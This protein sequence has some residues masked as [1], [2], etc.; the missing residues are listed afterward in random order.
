MRRLAV[1]A[2]LLAFPVSAGA[3]GDPPQL[4]ACGGTVWIAGAGY[5][6]RRRGARIKLQELA[7]P[8][9]IDSTTAAL[10]ASCMPKSSRLTISTRASCSKPSSSLA[11]R[12]KTPK[13]AA[14]GSR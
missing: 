12:S 5:R 11:S 3:G 9:S 4:A 13:Y 8:V 10:T 1:L 6:V 7:T 14:R 2:F